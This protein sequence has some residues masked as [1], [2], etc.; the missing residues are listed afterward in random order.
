M[1]DTIGPITASLPVQPAGASTFVSAQNAAGQN[2]AP[3]TPVAP[4]AQPKPPDLQAVSDAL[5]QHALDLQTS[6]RF[7]VDKITNQLVISVIDTQNNQLLMQ[8]PSQ[9][10]L[11]IAQSLE[12]LQAQLLNK[13]A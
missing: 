7:Q 1:T 5:N 6:L 9:E 4:A 13:Q 2:P 3:E 10:A 12:K 8:I 11:A